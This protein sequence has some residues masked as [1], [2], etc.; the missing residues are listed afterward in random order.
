MTRWTDRER[1]YFVT[2]VELRDIA[3]IQER[4]G[5]S[6]PAVVQSLTKLANSEQCEGVK[7]WEGAPNGSPSF[8]LKLTPA[9]EDVFS[10][11]SDL[12]RRTNALEERIANHKGK[13]QGQVRIGCQEV[14][15]EGPLGLLAPRFK[16]RNAL[17]RLQME[18]GLTVPSEAEPNERLD[19]ILWKPLRNG[20]LDFVFGGEARP[21]FPN[22][23]LYTASIVVDVHDR[24]PWRNRAA[25]DIEEVLDKR[26]AL[27]PQ[28]Y[29][30]RNKM[31]DVLRSFDKVQP[32][33]ELP[34]V[35]A[36]ELLRDSEI[37]LLG[38]SQQ[39]SATDE[40]LLMPIVAD[41][42]VGT[43]R[44]TPPYPKLTVEGRPLTGDICMHWRDGVYMN[45][46][47]TM[48]RDFVVENAP[49]KGRAWNFV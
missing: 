37:E 24:H 28:G 11:M 5:I 2:A 41:D 4:L 39:L 18:H 40:R 36:L 32:D 47:A 14:Q 19:E 43:L 10:G 38:G 3:A 17:I 8:P 1:L 13:T 29:F 16:R 23:I 21:D 26:I 25:V 6:R 27:L 45:S 7:L 35:R 42:G 48:F 46:Y 34:T 44:G 33:E 20:R 49:G 22:H 12:V 30:S 15:L 9:G 31:Q